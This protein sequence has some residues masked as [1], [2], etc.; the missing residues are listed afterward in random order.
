MHSFPTRRSSDLIP[1][2]NRLSMIFALTD[3]QSVIG[4]EHVKA[5]LA[6][7]EYSVNSTRL[8]FSDKLGGFEDK[9]LKMLRQH[10]EGLTRAAIWKDVDPSRRKA[11]EV[12]EALQALEAS[13]LVHREGAGK[14]ETW[15][16][17][18]KSVV[19]K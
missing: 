8:I 17:T 1:I 14:G 10:P 2:V 15:C 4:V 16:G 13:G 7:W 11:A 18:D 12:L 3:C 19:A 9:A 6:L 5:A